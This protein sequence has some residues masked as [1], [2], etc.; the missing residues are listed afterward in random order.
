MIKNKLI[1]KSFRKAFERSAYL[2]LIGVITF[3]VISKKKKLY[4]KVENAAISLI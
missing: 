4:K 3:A 2:L 1:P